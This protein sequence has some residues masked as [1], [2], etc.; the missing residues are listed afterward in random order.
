MANSLLY[1]HNHWNCLAFF[2]V[3]LRG[4]P[5]PVPLWPWPLQHGPAPASG[6]SSRGQPP[7]RPRHPPRHHP[8]HRHRRLHRPP[9]LETMQEDEEEKFNLILRVVVLK[10]GRHGLA[11][12]HYERGDDREEPRRPPLPA[13]PA[14]GQEGQH[15]SLGG[16][17]HLRLRSGRQAALAEFLLLL[18]PRR[19]QQHQRGI[20]TLLLVP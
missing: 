15:S 1:S 10:Q 20:V 5:P 9:D 13:S 19:Q 17:S 14:G 8:P 11:V 3:S 4:Q 18:R 7:T 12:H 16:E 2:S 6:Q